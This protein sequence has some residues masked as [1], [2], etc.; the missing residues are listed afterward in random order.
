[1]YL[2]FRG[3]G[4]AAFTVLLVQFAMLTAAVN[5]LDVKAFTLEDSAYVVV[6]NPEG[7]NITINVYDKH[8]VLNQSVSSTAS[9]VSTTITGDGTWTVKVLLN[10][11]EYTTEYLGIGSIVDTGFKRALLDLYNGDLSLVAIAI[12]A[13]I[14][15]FGITVGRYAALPIFLVTVGILSTNGYLPSWTGYLVL[16][17]A[18]FFLAQAIYRWTGG[19]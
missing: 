19:G 2:S 13:G 6:S 11:T 18:A 9:V 16:L 3:S 10:G 1:L 4:V 17:A 14:T 5:A 12:L 7:N 15:I 8:G